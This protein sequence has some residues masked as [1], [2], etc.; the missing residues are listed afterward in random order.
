MNAPTN[1]AENNLNNNED[2]LT[3]KLHTEPNS[4]NVIHDREDSLSFD[5]DW[6]TV[7][8]TIDT[9]TAEDI[10][11]IIQAKVLLP[12]LKIIILLKI[13]L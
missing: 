12:T 2:A 9:D 11:P 1:N 10:T 7:E 8:K 6:D 4:T 13:R 3:T 5:V